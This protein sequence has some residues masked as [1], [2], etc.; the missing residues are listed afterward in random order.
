[1]RE[2]D[3]MNTEQTK[4]E[5]AISLL[6]ELTEENAEKWRG[7]ISKKCGDDISNEE[8]LISLALA[9]LRAQQERENP[10]PLT[11]NVLKERIGKPIWTVT[12]GLDGSG[13]WELLETINFDLGFIRL[14]NMAEGS[15]DIELDS[16]GETWFA[17]DHES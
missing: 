8:E 5:R 7:E 3:G 10:Q 12:N 14:C 1:M 13:R 17:Y 15:Y 2:G 11:L 9:A 6:E 16:Y 4:Y